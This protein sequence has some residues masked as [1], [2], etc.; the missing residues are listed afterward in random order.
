[1]IRSQRIY[2]CIFIYFW[3]NT[4]DFL[5]LKLYLKF[6]CSNYIVWLEEASFVP[7]YYLRVRERSNF[8][9]IFI[10]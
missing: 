7:N 9:S 5:D 2:I 8:Y 1:M 4:I 3:N 10:G 6:S